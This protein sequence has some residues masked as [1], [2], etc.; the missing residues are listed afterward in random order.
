MS[1]GSMDYLSFKV[2]EARFRETTPE[3]KAFRKHLRL[4]AKALYDIE[5][6]DSG[7]KSDGAES[8]AIRACLGKTAV[9]I[10]AIEEAELLIEVLRKEVQK[11]KE[12]IVDAH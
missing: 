10:S 5:W 7:D 8:E 4:V 6:V 3:R 1:G 12:A 11:A 9:V 2:D